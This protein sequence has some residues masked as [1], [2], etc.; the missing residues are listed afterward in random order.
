MQIKNKKRISIH[1]LFKTFFNFISAPYIEKSAM[2]SC[3]NYH[4][5]CGLRL[6]YYQYSDNDD[7]S[8]SAVDYICRLFYDPE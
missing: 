2:T 7:K 6:K 5:I 8:V 3:P 1:V 4:V